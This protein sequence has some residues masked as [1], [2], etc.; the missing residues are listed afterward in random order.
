MSNA[1]GRIRF[2]GQGHGIRE[3]E[4]AA[5]LPRVPQGGG[6]KPKKVWALSPNFYGDVREE[7]TSPSC[8]RSLREEEERPKSVWALS[9]NLHGDVREEEDITAL[10]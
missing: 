10:L 4:D 2:E 6:E 5:A 9:P 7:A 8:F 1:D 3:E